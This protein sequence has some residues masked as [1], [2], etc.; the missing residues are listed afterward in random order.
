MALLL[1]GP[2]IVPTLLIGPCFNNGPVRGFLS[3]LVIRL[4]R[5]PEN[6]LEMGPTRGC[7]RGPG[8]GPFKGICYRLPLITYQ[9]NVILKTE[10]Y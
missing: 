1:I 3:I 5:G 6:D 9:R 8:E 7:D 10:I 2:T 4:M